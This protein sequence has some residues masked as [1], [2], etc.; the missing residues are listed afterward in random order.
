MRN[1]PPPRGDDSFKAFYRRQRSS[2]IALAAGLGGNKLYDPEQAAENGWQR[3]YPHWEACDNPSAYLRTCIVTAV[4]DELRAL[5][6][7]P[8]IIQ[9]GDLAEELAQVTPAREQSPWKSW[10]PPVAQAL[11]KLSDKLREAVALDIELNPG[12]RPVSEIARIL[13][14]NRVTAHMRLKRAYN[15]LE[16]LLPHGY[17][18]ERRERLRDAGGLEER[19]AP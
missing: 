15:Q 1:P 9:A 3:F 11:A 7:L 8:A 4:R 2:M 17:L 19:S 5:G 10:D 14:I 18:N 16:Q 13:G 6:D 12:E